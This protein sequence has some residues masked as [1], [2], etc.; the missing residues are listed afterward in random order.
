MPETVPGLAFSDG[1]CRF[2]QDYRPK[3]YAGAEQLQEVFRQ[4]SGKGRD[5]DCLVPISGGRDSAFI[6]YVARVEYGMRVLAV[7]YDNEFQPDQSVANMHAACEALGVPLVR[8]RSK[9][10]IA[11]KI[12]RSQVRCALPRGLLSLANAVCDACVYG[13]KSAV[14]RAAQKHKI[15]LILWGE[16]DVEATGELQLAAE[17]AWRRQR[18][19]RGASPSFLQPASYLARYYRLLQRMEFPVCGNSILRDKA[20]VLKSDSIREIRVFDYLPWDR[21]RIKETISTKLGWR[22]PAGSA[23]TWR[24]DSELVPLIN[25]CYVRLFGC[26]KSCFG[27]CR[28]INAGQME[29]KDAL[30]Q[31]EEL[32]ETCAHG[33]NRILHEIGVEAGR[34]PVD[35]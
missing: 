20:P 5:Y 7:S 13:Y 23:S 26:T 19:R 3:Q 18:P 10:D 15:P 24:T 29:R 32:L 12:V 27:Y 21:G 1:V 14:Y 17:N 31:E 4:A 9:R 22:K 30:G 33:A 35:G 16:S 2:C 34:I 8:V 25:W 11:R 28:M 6:L